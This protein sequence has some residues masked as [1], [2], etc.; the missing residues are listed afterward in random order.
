MSFC[1]ACKKFAVNAVNAVK[2][3]VYIQTSIASYS[4]YF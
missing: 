4:V 1:S 3:I 2:H